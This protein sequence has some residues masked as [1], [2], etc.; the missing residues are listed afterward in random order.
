[1]DQICR[2]ISVY[3]EEQNIPKK[4]TL[5]K[6]TKIIYVETGIQREQMREI[7]EQIHAR[8]E[9]ELPES[10]PGGERERDARVPTVTTPVG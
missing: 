2:Y 10:S 3:L 8:L 6:Y 1:M 9:K 5:A 7:P 4:S